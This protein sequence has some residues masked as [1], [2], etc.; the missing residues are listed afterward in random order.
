M[1]IY[2]TSSNK[3]Q[4]ISYGPT[5]AS[6]FFKN[7]TKE[8]GLENVQG[9]RFF[10]VD[11]N[12]DTYTDLVVL[13]NNYSIP[14][15]YRFDQNENKFLE[16][17]KNPFPQ[18]L[19]ASFLVFHDFD[20]DGILDV[21]V[22]ILN[23]KTELRKRPLRLF[24]GN[25]KNGKLTYNPVPFKSDPL[26]TSSLVLLDYNLDGHIDIF[27]GNYFKI[28]D[29]QNRSSPDLLWQG[30]GIKFQNQSIL[31]KGEQVFDKKFKNYKNAKPTTGASI[32]DV[33]LNGYPDVLTASAAGNENKMWLNL[34]DNKNTNRIFEDYG[35]TSGV[36]QDEEGAFLKHS[37]GNTFFTICADYN[38]NG[39]IDIA[40]GELKYAHE[41]PTRDPSSILSGKEKR[42]PPKFIRTT[43]THSKGLK[44]WSQA[45]RRGIFADI[46]F[47]GLT[48]LI[49]D[50]SGLPPTS[51]LVYF[52]QQ[53][54]HSFTNEA[55]EYG[56]DILNPSGTI[57]LDVN[58]DGNLDLLVGQT[59]VR[60][61]NIP[62]KVFLMVNSIPRKKRRSLRFYLHG[63]HSNA[64]GIGGRLI[65]KTN[66]RKM[67]Q[68]VQYSFGESPSQIEQGA[69]F[70][71]G[72][73]QLQ[74]LDVTWPFLQKKKEEK[75]SL[76]TKTYDL[77]Q[78]RF[79]RHLN[80]TLCEDGRLLRGIKRCF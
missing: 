22:G 13:P 41:P 57:V 77:S 4:E 56:L 79:L 45:D 49:I 76:L 20:K 68:F 39:I 42:F 23:K 72:K 37:G 32:C 34:Y 50:H 70:G 44:N 16:L 36:A 48:D 52:R 38:N 63:K 66:Q 25:I 60:D 54:D 29:K 1:P 80:I 18:V 53:N 12:N 43:Y 24:K 78:L 61:A 3:K 2:S 30:E 9:E 8:Y 46:D 31:L 10:A 28:G 71:I 58:R 26:P 15:F 6:S 17:K 64:Q 11:F 40:L 55:Q 73:D 69:Y 33:D 65:L 67:Q 62:R 14:K 47:D 59:N 21:I 7:K 35:K 51:R 5:S 19:R 74:S 75:Q 27:Q